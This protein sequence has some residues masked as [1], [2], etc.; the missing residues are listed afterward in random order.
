MCRQTFSTLARRGYGVLSLFLLLFGG[1]SSAAAQQ[2]FTVSS[3]KLSFGASPIGIQSPEH[4]VTITNN[5]TTRLT[6]SSISITPLQNFQLGLGWAPITIYRNSYTRFG[7]VFVPTA[8]QTYNGQLTINISGQNPI[9]ITLIG[10]GVTTGAVSNLNTTSL[11][12]GSVAQGTVSAPQNVTVTN[13]GTSPLNVTTIT[14]DPPF[15]VSGFTGTT[16][17]KPGASLPLQVTLSGTTP[18][19]FTDNMVI[20]YDVLP[21]SVVSLSG[22]VTPAASLAITTFPTLPSGT[23][24]SAYL[25]NLTATGGVG[26]L[27]WSLGSGAQLPAGLALSS[28][29][30]ISGSIASGVAAGTYS[31][32]VQVQDSA[33]PPN[34]ASSLLS[35]PIG[36]LTGAN[37]NNIS[38]N[39][40]NTSTPLVPL[41]DLG[42]GTY[43]G[44]EGGLYTSGSNVR[45]AA[46]DVAGVD[47]AQ[48]IQPLDANGNPDPN[49]RYVLVSIGMSVAHT[50]F[51]GF[52]T[53]ANLDPAKNSHLVIVNGAT[54]GS[55]VKQ[56]ADPTS[57][58]W[59]TM[60]NYTFPYA[61]VTF[62]QVVAAWVLDVETAPKGTF[63]SDMTQY[64]TDLTSLVQNLHTFF[65]NIKLAYL[66][67]IYYM[68][69]SNGIDIANPE[70]YAYE[71]GFAV[72]WVIQDQ[73][74]GNTDLNWNPNL[75]PVTAPWLSWGAYDWANGMLPRSDGLTWS[76][77]E[78]KS[79]G[80]HPSQPA[81]QEK[82][83]NLLLNFFKTDDTTAPWFLAH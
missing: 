23:Q 60:S 10:K 48:S 62:N 1:L 77:Q 71:G 54:P 22:S 7:L 11:N 5:C 20:S 38:F 18:A 80:I 64:Q 29:G 35:L 8:V 30:A 69:Y 76:C 63:P 33:V 32:A 36:A 49:G 41:T 26:A 27:T 53:D 56:W 12:F 82:E 59:T 16:F 37:C 25:A 24:N 58:L 46:H 61:G 73:L 2:C 31:V 78:R 65:P 9:V 68:G 19:S 17:L 13:K 34:T 66:N 55:S 81:G 67:S 45:P 70:P 47:L 72:K 52:E 83:A 4:A 3:L 57:G 50:N 6:V 79:D 39:V 21:P 74:D 44:Y 28:S 42:T 15:S 14:A 40:P 75:G 51:L 43:Q